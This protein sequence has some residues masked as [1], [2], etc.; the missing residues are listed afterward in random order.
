MM[1]HMAAK[2]TPK[3]KDGEYKMIANTVLGFAD[4]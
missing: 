2:A 4:I 3:V 1:R